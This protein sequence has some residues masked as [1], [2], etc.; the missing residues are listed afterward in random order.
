MGVLVSVYHPGSWKTWSR[1]ICWIESNLTLS[2]N[3]WK[4]EKERKGGQEGGREARTKEG[5]P[6]TDVSESMSELTF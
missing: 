2:Q 1:I 4:K 5:E 3:E 6:Q